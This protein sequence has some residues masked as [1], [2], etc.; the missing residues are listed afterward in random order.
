MAAQEETS[1]L[2]SID[3]SAIE[4][5]DPSLADGHRILYDREVPFELRIQDPSAGPQ[6]VGTLESIRVKVM[7]L[8]EDSSPQHLKLELT[9]ENDLFFHYLHTVDESSFR[10]MQDAQKLMVE[11]GEYPTILVRMLN[12]CIKEPHTFLAVFIMR[13]DGQA[14]LDFIQNIEYKFIELLSCDFQAATEELVRQQIT[15]RYTAAKH[16]LALLQ[17]R[18]QDLH[19]LVKVKNPSLLLQ[20]Q[21]A[22]RTS[23][24][25]IA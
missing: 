11:F 12:S 5:M 21:K 19:A 4:E 23:G 14:R 10:M 9:S 2:N 1:L 24:R 22:R 18:L 16:K 15:Y 13:R 20:M 17:A 6:E 3:F 25:Q 7:L 8:G